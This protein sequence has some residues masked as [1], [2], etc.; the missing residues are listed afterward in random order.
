MLRSGLLSALVLLVFS[1]LSAA[2][3]PCN[4]DLRYEAGELRWNSIP[5]V[6]QYQVLE[7]FDEFST[8][9]GSL[10]VKNSYPVTRRSSAPVKAFYQVTAEF[11]VGTRAQAVA[12]VD[13]CTAR[14]TVPLPADPELRALTRMAVLPIVGS[15]AGAA[16]AKF[17]T[18]LTL[19]GVSLKGKLVFHP[20]GH[21]ASPSDPSLP[22]ELTATTTSILYDDIVAA[23]GQSG[24]GS[25]DV[26][27]D[28]DATGRVPRIEARMFNETTGGT[29]GTFAPAVLPYQYLHPGAMQVQI[30]EGSR[31]RVN[32]GIRTLTATNAT[33]FIYGT[34]G[35]LR[36]FTE[37]SF[38]A[39][40]TLLASAADFL[41]KALAPGESVTLSFGGSAIPFYTIT[42]NTTNDPTLVVP[43]ARAQSLSVDEYVD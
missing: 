14:L 36:D 33:A 39:Q 22:Y 42:D 1:A 9:R 43:P 41:H 26:I 6:D 11:V 30:P 5:G 20:A 10:T 12:S 17:K 15:T 23:M 4:L 40:Y 38:P 19:R 2:A 8:M 31:F 32:L 28:A 7:S 3:N 24:L 34:D 21:A 25:I 18:S 37:L 29:F 13:T 27:P 35:R 16:G